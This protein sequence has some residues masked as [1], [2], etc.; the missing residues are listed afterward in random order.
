MTSRR[1]R[2]D[3]THLV[4]C[5]E[6]PVDLFIF[7]FILFFFMFS[8]RNKNNTD[9]LDS[10]FAAQGRANLVYSRR[11]QPLCLEISEQPSGI[12]PESTVFTRF[13]LAFSYASTAQRDTFCECRESLFQPFFKSLFKDMVKSRASMFGASPDGS[14]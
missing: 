7:S 5:S 11:T 8:V 10:S 2:E 14:S 3:P 4:A 6:M 12:V 1:D 13:L 9:Y